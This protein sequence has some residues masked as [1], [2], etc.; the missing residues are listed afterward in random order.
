M[1]YNPAHKYAL[2]VGHLADRL[3]G[4]ER[5]LTWPDGIGAIAEPQRKE[6]Q[7]L[8]AVKG[9]DIGEVDGILGPKTRAAIRDYQRRTQ[10][11]ADGFPRPELLE[12][13][14]ADASAK[15]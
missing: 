7:R 2:A 1:R 3:R 13:L 12:I 4:E 6:L 11:P 14:R 8:L 9:Y 5:T 10:R 15:P